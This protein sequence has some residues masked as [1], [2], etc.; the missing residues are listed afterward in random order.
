QA[1]RE[2]D[3]VKILEIRGG[4]GK[5]YIVLGKGQFRY[6]FHRVG[7]PLDQGGLPKGKTPDKGPG[8]GK[9]LTGKARIIMGKAVDQPNI[10]IMG[11]E[12]I[13]GQIIRNKISSEV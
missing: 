13:D 4:K 11:I 1:V 7:V 3:I 6:P 5:P 9:V 2:L 10:N 12:G 8:L